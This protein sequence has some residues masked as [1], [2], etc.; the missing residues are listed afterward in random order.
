MARS[1]IHKLR[2]EASYT[3]LW[4]RELATPRV[5]QCAVRRQRR[6]ERH[7]ARLALRGSAGLC[8]FAFTDDAAAAGGEG[9][10]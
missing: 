10:R 5:V 3:H 7:E 8:A 2:S 4:R 1:R 6:A 9:E